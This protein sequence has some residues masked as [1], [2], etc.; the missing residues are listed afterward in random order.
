M[1]WIDS[2]YP[3]SDEQGNILVK[4]LMDKRRIGWI[5]L[6]DFELIW[7]TPVILDPLNNKKSDVWI[8]PKGNKN[9]SLDIFK[10]WAFSDVDPSLYLLVRWWLNWLSTRLSLRS[11]EWV[12]KRLFMYSQLFV[13]EDGIGEWKGGT[14]TS[15]LLLERQ[16]FI[17]ERVLRLW[18]QYHLR[19]PQ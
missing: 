15:T 16:S 12:R 8:P 4:D 18:Q 17:Y 14:S 1:S 11:W 19:H 7:D 5:L 10:R 13:V 9:R 2:D 3:Y 6:K